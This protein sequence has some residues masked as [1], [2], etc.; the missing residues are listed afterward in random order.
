MYELRGKKT[1]KAFRPER[2]KTHR[3]EAKFG[4]FRV[5]CGKK[6]DSQLGK[7]KCMASGIPDRE[8]GRTESV[9]QTS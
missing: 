7:G 8:R 9:R 3:K 1:G 5:T 4:N 2:A 6:F